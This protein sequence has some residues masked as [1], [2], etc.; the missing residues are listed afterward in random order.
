MVSRVVICLTFNSETIS[1]SRKKKKPCEQSSKNRV[2]RAAM[3]RKRE[4]RGYRPESAVLRHQGPATPPP[5]TQARSGA[6]AGLLEVVD[7][8]LQ[9]PRPLRAVHPPSAQLAGHR[10]AGGQPRA[11][12]LRAQDPVR[13]TR[14][15]GSSKS[16]KSGGP[17][18][19]ASSQA[20]HGWREENLYF[21]PTT[22]TRQ[23]R[24][25]REDLPTSSPW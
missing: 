5:P 18:P 7:Q 20:P 17:P 1:N 10:E 8:R 2:F 23:Q 22:Y 13:C 4:P 16:P 11:V 19:S 24:N 3:T 21:K 15:A 12:F 9:R 6:H 25:S 14:Q